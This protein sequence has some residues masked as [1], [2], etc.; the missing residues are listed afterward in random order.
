ML[1][2]LVRLVFCFELGLMSGTHS[3]SQRES[4]LI[5][6]RTTWPSSQMN[7]SRE[8][9]QR[10]LI[11]IILVRLTPIWDEPRNESGAFLRENLCYQVQPI[12]VI[13][14]AGRCV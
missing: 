9:K 5:G 10:I 2:L 13:P 3:H 1:H 8:I 4:A 14:I 11:F 12:Y 7:Q 6:I